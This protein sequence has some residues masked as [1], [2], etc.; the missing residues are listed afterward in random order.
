MTKTT[1]ALMW[2]KNYLAT[3]HALTGYEGLEDCRCGTAQEFADRINAMIAARPAKYSPEMRRLYEEKYSL[4]AM[5]KMF[6]EI[7]TGV[8]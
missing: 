2:G 4:S 7:V 6:R 8:K 3:G 1:E 5:T